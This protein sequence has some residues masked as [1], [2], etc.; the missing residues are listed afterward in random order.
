LTGS[1]NT[2]LGQAIH[3]LRPEL[4]ESDIR[5]S[6]RRAEQEAQDTE[7]TDGAAD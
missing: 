6:F 1:E 4:S 7:K 5:K 2:S 3:A